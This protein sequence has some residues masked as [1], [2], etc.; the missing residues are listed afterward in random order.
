MEVNEIYGKNLTNFSFLFATDDEELAPKKV[1]K[2]P[3][4]L[5]NSDDEKSSKDDE[6]R[7]DLDHP[8][9]TI[10]IEEVNKETESTDEYEKL[11]DEEQP[12]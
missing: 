6:E 8:G 7:L 5:N 9:E 1:K 2:T 12:T 10:T 3:S 11:N 4:D